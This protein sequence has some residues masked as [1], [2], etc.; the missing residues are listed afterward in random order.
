MKLC[1]ETITVFNSRMAENTGFDEYA[2][3]VI[4]GVSW[5]NTIASSVIMSGLKATDSCVIRIPT[6]AD[7]SG[8][9]FVSPQDYD[10]SDPAS[11]FTLRNGDIIV[12]GTASGSVKPA[13]LHKQ[14]E[15]I[16]I[17]GVTDNRRNRRSPHWKV[18][19]T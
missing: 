13:E 17:L 14:Y 7:F 2:A 6:N 15:A 11:S 10:M 16:T 1:C 9:S 5:H 18:V 3:T 12:R 19:G 4:S 8:K